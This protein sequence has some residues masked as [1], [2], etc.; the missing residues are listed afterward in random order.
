MWKSVIKNKGTKSEIHQ[1]LKEISNL[2]VRE[3][4]NNRLD[5]YG[6]MNGSTG[7]LLFVNY[8][9][10]YSNTLS[11]SYIINNIDKILL[12][13]KDVPGF[14]LSGGLGGILW[15]IKSLTKSGFI[16]DENSLYES[17]TAL[18]HDSLSDHC[19]K[20]NF[21]YLHGA[22]GIALYLLDSE[23]NFDK[24]VLERWLENFIKTSETADNKIT[25]KIL[26]NTE[27]GIKGYCLGLAHGTPSIILIIIKYLQLTKSKTGL[28]ILKKSI[29][30]LMDSAFKDTTLSFFPDTIV[31][32]ES[33]YPSRLAWCYGD[34]G[35]ALALYKAGAF[36]ADK[37]L[38]NQALEIMLHSSQR[39]S[40]NDNFVKDADF[41]HGSAGIAHFFA[42][43][44]NYTN[45]EEFRAASEYW[46]E[47]TLE[48]GHFEDGLAG[49]K[50]YNGATKD[51]DC[52]PGLLEGVSGIGLTFISAV[53]K[54]EPKWDSC[55]LLS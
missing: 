37:D 49:F 4:F 12:N 11:E 24:K 9:D 48:M 50:H 22:F 17:T 47:K 25:R 43:F 53:S 2:I 44:Y 46:F 26:L 45:H 18:F 13:I 41:C 14:N 23:I 33:K 10:K 1:K 28:D 51:Y 31:N 42:R 34:L 38:S 30:H 8:Y 15:A 27:T 35:C 19:E 7:P 3:D 40:I 21:D 36:L 55:F 20:N 39:R 52:K 32:G 54:I 16:E 6:L 29:N 5:S